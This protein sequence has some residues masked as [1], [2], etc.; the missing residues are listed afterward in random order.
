MS[1]HSQLNGGGPNNDDDFAPT[2][3]PRT[4]TNE[5]IEHYLKNITDIDIYANPLPSGLDFIDAPPA[6]PLNDHQMDQI[7]APTSFYPP[8]QSLP[9]VERPLFVQESSTSFVANDNDSPFIESPLNYDMALDGHFLVPG[10]QG[11]YRSNSNHSDASSAVP[12]PHLAATSPLLPPAANSPYYSDNGHAVTGLEQITGDFSL[13]ES[14]W[15]GQQHFFANNTMGNLN[16][17]NNQTNGTGFQTSGPPENDFDVTTPE[18]TIDVV[19]HTPTFSPYAS[20]TGSLSPS[21]S[22]MEAFPSLDAQHGLFPPAVNRRRSHSDSD[23]SGTQNGHL[24]PNDDVSNISLASE[25]YLSPAAATTRRERVNHN[26]IRN[27][28]SSA[29]QARERSRSR[30][31]SA[32]REYILELASQSPGP[33]KVQRHPSTFECDLCDKK[34]TRAYNLRSHKRTHTNERPYACSVCDKAFARQHDRKR[35]EAL[36]SGE[37]KFECKGVLSDGATTWGCGHKFARADALGRHFR[38]EAGKECIRLLVEESEREKGY[39][40]IYGGNED[41]PALTLSP[42][43]INEPAPNILGNGNSEGTIH[44]YSFP[45]ALLEQFPMLTDFR[46]R[47]D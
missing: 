10:N 15:D 2:T 36:H 37:K 5:L 33:K 42:P 12:S 14:N 32:S 38:T 25:N 44:D 1:Q 8:Q 45:Q 9:S 11:H 27:R 7:M 31:Q 24:Y 4:T 20:S 6:A 35:H 40:P 41:A 29:S 13:D 28:S 23:L 46:R 18:I 21:Y 22:D 47:D 26:G 19:D 17:N 3:L 34:F 39:V 30:S 43:P 16:G